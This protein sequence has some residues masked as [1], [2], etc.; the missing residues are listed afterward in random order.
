MFAAIDDDDDDDKHGS[1]RRDKNDSTLGKVLEKAGDLLGSDKL[2]QRGEERR[3]N[4]GN[5]D[6]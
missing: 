5:D 4:K 6:Y 1:S 3:H 2:G